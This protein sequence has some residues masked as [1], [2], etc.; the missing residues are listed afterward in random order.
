MVMTHVV[1]QVLPLVQGVGEGE[2]SV[3]LGLQLLG[4]CGVWLV[5]LSQDLVCVHIFL[6]ARC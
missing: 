1:H 6:P 5:G 3:K 4:L 2:G